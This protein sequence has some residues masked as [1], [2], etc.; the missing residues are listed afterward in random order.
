[1]LNDLASNI[2][3]IGRRFNQLTRVQNALN[4]LAGNTCPTL[5]S[6]LT[7][8]AAAPLN[9]RIGHLGVR[10]GEERWT[11]HLEKVVRN[12]ITTERRDIAVKRVNITPVPPRMVG[13]RCP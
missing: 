11:V 1:M 7:S 6:G 13:F 12:G 4:D 10:S 9:G 8:G 5:M 2:C 3:F